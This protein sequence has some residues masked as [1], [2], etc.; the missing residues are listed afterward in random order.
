MNVLN[1][2]T[3]SLVPFIFDN[4]F[5]LVQQTKGLI[6]LVLKKGFM[7]L[8]EPQNNVLYQV[9]VIRAGIRISDLG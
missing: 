8:E 9:I 3:S 2:L 4:W 7:S 5:S 1:K 6:Q